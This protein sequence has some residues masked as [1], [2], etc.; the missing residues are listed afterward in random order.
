MLED[1]QVEML[2]NDLIECKFERTFDDLV[3]IRQ[4]NHLGLIQVAEFVSGH[5]ALL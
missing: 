2:L 5:R 4:W 1:G 3:G